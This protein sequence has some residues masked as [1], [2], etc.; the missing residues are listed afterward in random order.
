M[1]TKLCIANSNHNHPTLISAGQLSYVGGSQAVAQINL[2]NT[3]VLQT[4]GEAA[5]LIW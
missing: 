2:G 5:N 4:G 1:S 3:E